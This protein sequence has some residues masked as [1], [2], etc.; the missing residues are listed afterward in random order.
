MDVDK[1][2]LDKFVADPN[3]DSH[4]KKQID[5]FKKR[6]HLNVKATKTYKVTKGTQFATERKVLETELTTEML[7][8]GEWKDK[9]FKK[10]NFEADTQMGMGGHC[11]PLM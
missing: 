9:A 11:H 3:P 8:T 6:K 5:A 10:Y 1:A 2:Q 7:R 4:D